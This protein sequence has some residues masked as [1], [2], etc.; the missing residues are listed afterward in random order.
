MLHAPDRRRQAAA[1]RL[2]LLMLVLALALPSGPALASRR[3]DIAAAEAAALAGRHAEAARLYESASERRFFG[4]DRSV[5]LLAAREY[6]AAGQVDDADR[7]ADAA[8][9]RFNDDEAILYARIRAQIALAQRDPGAA[10]SAL[11]QA[12]EPLPAAV[13]AEFEELRRQAE[14]MLRPPAP[15]IVSPLPAAPQP[16]SVMGMSREE[17]LPQGSVERVALLLPL[18]GRLGAVGAAVREGFIAGWYGESADYRPEVA[19]YD[20]AKSGVSAAFEQALAEQAQFVVGPLTKDDVATLA[21][22]DDIYVPVLALNSYAGASPPPFLYRFSL[23]PEE[24]A[25]AVARRIAADGHLRGIALFPGGEWGERVFEAF[26]SE[27]AAA[28]LVILSAQPFNPGATDF[29]GPLRAALGR[30]AGAGD[31]KDGKPAPKRDAVAEARDGPQFAFVAAS[32]PVA[33]AIKPQLRFQMSYVL[34]VYST[35]DAWEPG[36]TGVRDMNGLTFPELPWIL[37]D[38]QGAP[39]LWDLTSGDWARQSRGLLRLYAFGFDAYQLMRSLRGSARTFGLAGLTGTLDIDA[40]G[41]VQR[42][43]EFA[44]VVNGEAE[45]AGTAIFIPASEP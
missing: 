1:T 8:R 6:L 12:P 20:T 13:E 24:E 32:A 21:A 34:P 17:L 4:T 33:R 19:I 29:S 28:G 7:M 10:L 26:N 11:E 37:Y 25:R 2:L 14:T 5:A 45:P 27:A 38:G 3:D 23:D 43:I 39:G 9:G 35:S 18:S 42:Q 15:A 40:S 44:R 31:R 36:A 16:E 22:R 30:F 41:I